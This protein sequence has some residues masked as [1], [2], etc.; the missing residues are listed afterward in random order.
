MCQAFCFSLPRFASW[1]DLTFDSFVEPS[2]KSF[3]IVSAFSVLHETFL[4]CLYTTL[5]PFV[6]SLVRSLV[7]GFLLCMS[8][9]LFIFACTLGNWCIFACLSIC[10]LVCAI[11]SVP[12]SLAFAYWANFTASCLFARLPVLDFLLSRF[13]YVV[14]D[15]CRF[16]FLVRRWGSSLACPDACRSR[17]LVRRWG[18]SLA[19]RFFA[20]SSFLLDARFFACLVKFVYDLF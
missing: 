18:S 4:L 10:L 9:S 17:F 13:F 19:R 8:P 7:R 1:V 6:C 2:F 16:R 15:A 12:P 20:I 11:L 3:W 14:S 5:F